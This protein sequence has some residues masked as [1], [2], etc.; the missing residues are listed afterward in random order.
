MYLSTMFFFDWHNTI[1]TLKRSQFTEPRRGV[2]L[3]KDI[4]NNDNLSS[5]GATYFTY[6]SYGA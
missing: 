2:M 4:N 6:R 1:K 5:V 3:V